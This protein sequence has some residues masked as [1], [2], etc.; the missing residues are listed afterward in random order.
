MRREIGCNLARRHHA[1]VDQIPQTGGPGIPRLIRH[2][3]MSTTPPDVGPRALARLPFPSSATL[4]VLCI[5]F[6]P[7]TVLCEA[8]PCARGA[9]LPSFFSIPAC[10]AVA[11]EDPL[12]RPLVATSAARSSRPSP[13]P[14]E[15]PHGTVEASRDPFG[16]AVPFSRP[17]LRCRPASG[18]SIVAAPCRVCRPLRPGAFRLR[19]PLVSSS[20]PLGSSWLLGR[21]MAR[22]MM[23]F[24]DTG[25]APRAASL[26]S[27]SSWEPMGF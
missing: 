7:F 25:A 4:A 2:R 24:L 12:S 8:L 15:S 16:S 3:G 26:R 1:C 19:I 5:S 23:P 20:S 21:M 27:V 10:A 11:A 14:S 22:A 13:R 17:G 9:P 6:C 18:A